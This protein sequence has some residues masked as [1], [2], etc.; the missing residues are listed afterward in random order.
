[1]KIIFRK[2]A[3]LGLICTPLLLAAC[4]GGEYGENAEMPPE[5]QTGETN[6][7]GVEG[8]GDLPGTAATDTSQYV[9]EA[10]GDDN[11]SDAAIDSL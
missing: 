1:M 2:I 8:T 4:G 9:N 5:S 7:S 11:A 6:E 10:I 3:V